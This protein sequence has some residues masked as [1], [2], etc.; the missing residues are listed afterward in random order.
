MD[1]QYNIN[2]FEQLMSKVK[3]E[4]VDQLMAFIRK[5]DFYTAPAST[6][7]HLSIEGG[8]LQHSLNVYDCLMA[9]KSDPVWKEILETAGD[10]SLIISA[11]FHDL[12]KTYFY[13]KG[14]KN[15]KSY[16]P[17]K[18]A[19]AEKWQVKH[20]NG[21]DF[22][23]E[24]VDTYEVNDQIPYG[25]GE[26]SVMMIENYMKLTSP[27][28]YAIRWHMGHTEPKENWN[29]LSR[30][31]ENHPLVL[32]LHIADMEASNLLEGNEGNKREIA[33]F[34]EGD[35]FMEVKEADGSEN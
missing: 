2:R 32:A 18:V 28:R 15:Q 9:K 22:I 6:K 33:D 19:A 31:I 8:L 24:I 27:E 21:G 11:L 10:E 23:W 30:A 34:P 35:G 7:Y 16:D 25:H 13:T 12:C 14:T 4:G 26:K 3:R 20:D 17:G 1:R 29:Y 5:S